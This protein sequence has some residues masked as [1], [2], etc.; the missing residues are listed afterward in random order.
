MASPKSNFQ[1]Y[2][3][4]VGDALEGAAFEFGNLLANELNQYLEDEDIN[5][6]RDMQKSIVQETLRD[7]DVIEV[8]AGPKVEYAEYVHEGTDP[9]LPPYEPLRRWVE[10]R[11]L[12]SG[13]QDRLVQF[14][15][16][17]GEEVEFTATVDLAHEVTQAVRYKIAKEGITANP[18]LVRFNEEKGEEFAERYAEIIE[19]RLDIGD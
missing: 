19:N 16:G 17:S 10:A 3:A 6:S 8:L 4:V 13:T 14:T 12:A 11:G 9:F 2:P 18:F 15:T 1:D 5:V 7:G